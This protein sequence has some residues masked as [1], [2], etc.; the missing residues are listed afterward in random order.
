M[1]IFSVPL[2][3]KSI[4]GEMD[5]ISSGYSVGSLYISSTETVREPLPHT[6]TERVLVPNAEKLSRMLLV[7]PL[8]K[9]TMTMTAITPMMMPS[10]VRKV[11]SLL[12][13]TFWMA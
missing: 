4:C 3:L 13:H 8:P 10:M 5:W 9:P 2:P 7:M 12:L 6:C 1:P 11:R